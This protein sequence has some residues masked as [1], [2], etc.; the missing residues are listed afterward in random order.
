DLGNE[1]PPRLFE[2]QADLVHGVAFAPDGKRIASAGFDHTVRTWDAGSG[3]GLLTLRGHALEV[4]GVAF[5]PQGKTLASTSGDRSVK[6]WDPATGEELHTLRGHTG[7]VYAAAFDP[8]DR[9]DAGAAPG[10]RLVSAGA[11]GSIKAW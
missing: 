10:Q 5:G 3:K 11:D 7:V 4:L 2:S 9:S 1:E 6:V 8:R